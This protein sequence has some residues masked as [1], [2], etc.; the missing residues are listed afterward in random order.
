MRASWWDKTLFYNYSFIIKPVRIWPLTL[1]NML[2]QE[3]DEFRRTPDGKVIQGAAHICR[4]LNHKNRNSV[5]IKAVCVLRK[6]SNQFDSIACCGASGLLVVPQ[7]AELLEKNIVLIRKK[8]DKCYSDFPMEG[9]TPFRYV[10]IDDLICSGST[11]KHIKYTI[12][13]DSP[14]ARCVGSYF[15]LPEE[16]AYNEKNSKLF[17]RD[18]G[19]IL[20]N[21]LAVTNK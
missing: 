19:M 1:M 17:E 11:I 9:V 16:C 21:P 5:I 10:I 14:R 18:F 6:I 7:I 15:Y 3:L 20:L 2:K 12:N 4:V 13:E 8:G